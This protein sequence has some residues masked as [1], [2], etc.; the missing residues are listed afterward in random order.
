MRVPPQ[1]VTFRTATL[2]QLIR[3]LWAL[4]A[5]Q[6]YSMIYGGCS[7]S[8]QRHVL[9]RSNVPPPSSPIRYHLVVFWNFS[10]SERRSFE[11]SVRM[12]VFPRSFRINVGLGV[13]MWKRT[14]KCTGRVASSC[15]LIFIF[16]ERFSSGYLL[17]C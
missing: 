14:T 2:I 3:L 7:R 11:M 5:P 16:S 8:R 13:D 17:C 12:D 4:K 6:L 9:L 1:A 15:L 10:E